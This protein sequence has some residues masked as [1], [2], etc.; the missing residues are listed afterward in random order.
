[1]DK[2]LTR[3][4]FLAGAALLS[5]GVSPLSAETLN[6]AIIESPIACGQLLGIDGSAARQSKEV[7]AVVRVTRDDRIHYLGEPLGV[8][9]ATTPEAAAEA[10]RRCAVTYESRPA[11]LTTAAALSSA[12][13][14]PLP[15]A[16]L[17]ISLGEAALTY[18]RGTPDATLEK[19]QPGFILKQ[20]YHTAPELPPPEDAPLLSRVIER[21]STLSANG[22]GRPGSSVKLAL[23][24][25]EA[26]LL[27]GS[28]PETIQ[29]LTLAAGRDGR[30]HALVHGSLND[31]AMTA[32]YVEPCGVLS[33]HLYQIDH[34]RV[35]HQIVRKNIAP[36]AALPAAGLAPGLFALESALDELAHWLKLDPVRLRL[37]NHAELD[38]VTGRPW[39]NKRLRECYRLGMERIGWNGENGEPS[40]SHE[41]R[42]QHRGPL[43]V[44]LGMASAMGWPRPGVGSTADAAADG[45]GEGTIDAAFG[46][47]F[48][49]VL[50]DPKTDRVS[51]ARHVAVLDL[52]SVPDLEQAR[53]LA[54]VGIAL[55]HAS[56]LPA[57]A[58]PAS[59][60]KNDGAD[61][62]PEIEVLFVESDPPPA[63]PPAPAPVPVLDVKAVRDLALSGVAAAVGSAV[64]NATGVRHRELPIRPAEMI[65]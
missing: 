12:H 25:K 23:S 2:G 10:V 18:E 27:S 58:A 21:L 48:V 41:P 55:G 44:G 15:A 61:P 40:R 49:R 39:K 42:T 1:M 17:P 22:A 38:L 37:I 47:H 51:I 7:L 8:V 33:R 32:E 5:A 64:H 28:R 65:R 26:Q 6:A 52:G 31:T 24:L 11:V 53:F 62:P 29:T 45:R 63:R 19:T 57:L 13:V 3:R 50:V 43:L 54:R 46:A 34:L 14:P 35:T 59:T 56:A 16:P 4:E 36:R 20:T 9:V 30:L 60:T